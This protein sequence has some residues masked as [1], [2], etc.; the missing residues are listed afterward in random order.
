MFSVLLS[1]Y[2]K[3]NPDYLKQSLDSLFQ[4]TL[5]ADEII[6][7]KDGPLTSELDSIIDDYRNK[8]K[9]ITVISL[10]ENEGLGIALNEGLNHCSHNLVAR[11]DTD[12]IA[13]PSRFEKQIQQFE[14]DPELDV[15]GSWVD[16]FVDSKE[17]IVSKRKVPENHR[18]IYSFAKKRN[19][20][21]HPSVMFKKDA[22]LKT[23]NYQH[24]PLFED[25]YLW[26]RM[27]MSGCKFYNIQE[28][29]LY[30]R[31]TPQTFERRGGVEYLKN[32]IKLQKTF[33]KLKFI[34]LYTYLM[35]VFI[36]IIV[37]LLPNKP[38][39]ALYGALVRNK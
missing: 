2:Y 35:N 15:V 7:M 3:E 12:D 26:A 19:P 5:L 22:V 38:R 36:R 6:L 31:T 20:I 16:E 28:S 1:I 37:R 10:K 14:L 4:Q 11:M 25:Y 23:G 8:Y 34:S 33:Y 29:L 9:T 24:F 13:K 18:E 39:A 21:N 32:E 30:F 27:L 17:N